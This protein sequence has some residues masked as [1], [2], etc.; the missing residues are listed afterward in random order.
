MS[1]SD[2]NCQRQTDHVYYTLRSYHTMWNMQIADGS[3]HRI[4]PEQGIV[5]DRYAAFL[6]RELFDFLAHIKLYSKTLL[7]VGLNTTITCMCSVSLNYSRVVF[8]HPRCR[9]VTYNISSFPILI[10]VNYLSLALWFLAVLVL[11][12]PLGRRWD[13]HFR[14]RPIS[15]VNVK[16]LMPDGQIWVVSKGSWLYPISRL[17]CTSN[18]LI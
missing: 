10:C 18:V 5:S 1:S 6:T 3:F 16:M 8:V 2:R 13:S 9:S 7:S 14:T 12:V 11:A 15:P 4:P 17:R